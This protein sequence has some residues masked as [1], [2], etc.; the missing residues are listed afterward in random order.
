[1]R[2][3]SR[4]LKCSSTITETKRAKKYGTQGYLSV[5]FDEIQTPV[6]DSSQ[7]ASWRLDEDVAKPWRLALTSTLGLRDYGGLSFKC[8]VLDRL[9]K[10]DGGRN[11]LLT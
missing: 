9:V 3:Q 7:L 5:I 6:S 2:V 11:F 10:G 1:M 8:M 4:S